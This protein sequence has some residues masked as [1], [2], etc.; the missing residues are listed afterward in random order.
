MK[1]I[2]ACLVL[3]LS[4]SLLAMNNETAPVSAK[5][6]ASIAAAAPLLVCP[7]IMIPAAA[8]IASSPLPALIARA[9]IST[10]CTIP[11][12]AAAHAL[13]D[14]YI[15]PCEKKLNII[16]K[17]II[18]LGIR[19]QARSYLTYCRIIPPA[20]SAS[21][22]S[23]TIWTNVI[24]GAISTSTQS[25]L[26]PRFL[27]ALAARYTSIDSSIKVRPVNDK[28]QLAKAL[29][30]LQAAGEFKLDWEPEASS[31]ISVKWVNSNVSCLPSSG[32]LN[33]PKFSL[34]IMRKDQVLIVTEAL[35]ITHPQ[36]KSYLVASG[37]TTTNTS[38]L[39]ELPFG[40]DGFS[41]TFK[42]LYNTVLDNH[43]TVIGVPL[44]DIINPP[45][46]TDAIDL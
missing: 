20:L 43:K 44:K 19:T 3:C 33:T 39:D 22:L 7:P 13:C 27:S 11:I 38:L 42:K 29:K 32:L 24:D 45:T 2:V 30:K 12:D 16:A 35:H 37:Y 5:L 10:A 1:P 18:S 17:F 25:L 8:L 36:E 46:D 15:D 41:P 26:E 34:G 9:S 23:E 4:N 21:T 28:S 31:Q 14:R 6:Q 40:L